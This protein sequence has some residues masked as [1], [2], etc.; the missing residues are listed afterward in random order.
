LGNYGYR[1]ANSLLQL[2]PSPTNPELQE[3]EKLPKV[4]VQEAFGWQASESSHSLIARKD[5]WTKYNIQL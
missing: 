3:H 1:R 2:N 4:S 5:I